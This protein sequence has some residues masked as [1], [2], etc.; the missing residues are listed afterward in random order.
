MRRVSSVESLKLSKLHRWEDRD[1]APELEPRFP[2]LGSE[3][4]SASYGPPT[5]AFEQMDRMLTL[6]R[7]KRLLEHRPDAIFSISDLDSV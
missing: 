4:V 1:R 6:P 5:C 3:G 7:L 2:N